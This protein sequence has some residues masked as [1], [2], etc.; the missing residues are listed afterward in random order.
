MTLTL[1]Q[2]DATTKPG[3]SHPP[4]FGVSNGAGA[5]GAA[6]QILD[7]PPAG[8]CRHIHVDRRARLCRT[9]LPPL[10]PLRSI[11]RLQG[12]GGGRLIVLHAFQLLGPTVP[13]PDTSAVRSR[14]PAASAFAS[15]SHLRSP[16]GISGPAGQ[17]ARPTRASSRGSPVPMHRL[18]RGQPSPSICW[19]NSERPVAARRESP[20]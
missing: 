7:R 1:F 8:T 4:D 12:R 11:H 18:A 9:I 2:G 14:R 17:P 20:F 6:R 13:Y 15:E 19:R 5:T 10:Y 3:L 16:G